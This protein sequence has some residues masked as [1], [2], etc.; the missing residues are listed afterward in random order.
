MKSNKTR[1]RILL[2]AAIVL[3]VLIIVILVVTG[4]DMTSATKV[5]LIMTGNASDS[6]WNGMHYSGVV[7]ACEKLEAKLMIKENITEGTGMCSKAI[8]ELVSDGADVV[9]LSSYGYPEEAADTISAYPDIAFYGIYSGYKAD[10]ITTYFG[11]M[12]QARYLSGIVAG[13]QS[14]TGHIGYVAAMSNNEVNRGIN[15]F[16]L[17]VKSV[18]PDAEVYVTWTDSWDN[19]EAE[20]NAVE[21]LVNEKGVDLITCHQNQSYAAEAADALGVYSIG[22]N[23]GAEGLSDKYLTAVVW[24]WDSLYYEIIREYVQ[25]RGNAVG[26]RWFGLDRGVV[27]LSDYS[28]LVGEDIRLAVDNARNELLSGGEVFSGD[29]YDIDGVQRCA[30]GERIGDR[31]LLEAMD[32]F[33]DGVVIYE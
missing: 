9:I 33:V 3:V 18:A 25:G 19:A 20:I 30:E 4:M 7:S 2:I 12:Y 24:N 13:M 16:T 17:G 21:R 27:G 23:E 29:I 11:R 31:I 22:Y 26:H 32:W 8:D 6:G 15:A 14:E 28:P 1:Q 10:N 5:G